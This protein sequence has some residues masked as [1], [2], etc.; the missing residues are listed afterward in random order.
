M[1]K[2]SDLMSLK[3]RRA[4]ITGATGGIGQEIALTIAELGGDLLLVDR[5]SS[6]YGLVTQKIFDNW[7]V[8]IECIDCDL[9]NEASRNYLIDKAIKSDKNLD[10]LINN[11]AFVG[12][13]NLEGWVEDFDKQSLETWNRALEVNLTAPFHLSQAFTPLLRKN[14]NG[15]I[16]NIASIYGMNAPDYSLY[17]GTNMGN[18]AGYSA[19]KGGLIQ[20]TSWLAT[21]VSPDIR[22]NSIS[23][24]GVWRNQPSKFVE[25]YESRTPLGR[26]ATEED[27]KGVVAYLASDLSAYVTGQNIVVDGGWTA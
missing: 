21:T 15:S 13:S 8:N 10:I 23:P 20:L 14:N 9:E 17:E 1:K 2:I 18:P 16:I 5:P 24:G 25:R 22:V 4:L 11:A 3:G 12:E 19:S 6:D 7:D 27:F 26:M